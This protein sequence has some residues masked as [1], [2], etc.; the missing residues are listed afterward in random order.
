MIQTFSYTIETPERSFHYTIH[1]SDLES[2][3]SKWINL[4]EDLQNEV[5]SFNRSEVEKINQQYLTGN[6]RIS[7][8]KEP[9]FLNYKVDDK[10]QL[11]NVKRVDKGDPDFIAKVS[12]LTT[13]EG[14][15]KGFA[16]SGYRPHVKFDGRKELTSGEQLFTDREKVFP[17][18]TAMAEI[19]ILA[20]EIFKNYLYT[21]Q[22]FSFSEGAR[23]IGRGQIIEVI[24]LELLA[25]SR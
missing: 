10:Y 4:I 2:S 20:K 25:A 15:R 16:A 13:E 1:S 22:H 23:L 11:V 19:R 9:F 24:N 7:F 5:Y 17:G 6:F 3:V 18:E 21:G 14:G 12:Y 8:E